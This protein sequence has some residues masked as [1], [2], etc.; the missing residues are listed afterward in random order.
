[1]IEF[2]KRQA[3][4]WRTFF[5]HDL[6]H[7]DFYRYPKIR[8]YLHHQ[9]MLATLVF[10]AFWADRFI[11]SASALV[12]T[13]LFAIV[14]FL[15]VIFYFMKLL[16]WQHLLAPVL[17]FLLSPLGRRGSSEVISEIIIY[18]EN[19]DLSVLGGVGSLFLIISLLF[20]ISSIETAF[21]QIWKA[22]KGRAWY[23]S[24]IDYSVIFLIGPLLVLAVLGTLFSAKGQSMLSHLPQFAFLDRLPALILPTFVSLAAFSYIL[25]FIPNTRV[26][27]KSALVGSLVGTILW[28]VGNWV[29]AT[30]IVEYYSSGPQAQIYARLAIL[31]LFLLWMFYG[32]TVLL[33]AAQV[34]YAHQNLYKLIW[35]QKHPYIGAMFHEMIGLKILLRVHQQHELYKISSSEENLSDYFHIPEDVINRTAQQLVDLGYLLL[36]SGHARCYLPTQPSDKVFVSDV[37]YNLRVT[38]CGRERSHRNIDRLIDSLCIRFNKKLGYRLQ[39]VTM[40]DLLDR[41]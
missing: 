28:N 8:K 14:P 40:H 29:F 41:L 32:W 4:R 2:I 39:K 21:N 16:S 27:W 26:R 31:P 17:T 11:D 12:F 33:F 20:I 5:T 10:R 23:R 13:S 24:L 38:G 37:L 18:V 15:A 9:F 25:A 22:K 3:K 19:S 35:Q 30:F 7:A 6:W 1:M 34:S 36:L